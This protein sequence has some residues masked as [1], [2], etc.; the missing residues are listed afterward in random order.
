MEQERISE[1]LSGIDEDLLLDTMGEDGSIKKRWTSK[2]MVKIA[3][4]ACF[5]LLLGA[6]NSL[7]RHLA[8]GSTFLWNEAGTGYRFSTEEIREKVY[9]ER[10]NG[11]YYIFE[12]SELNITDYCSESDYFLYLNLDKNGTGYIVVVGG[13]EGER[14]YLLKH[15]QQGEL[16][17]GQGYSE[18]Y[19][20]ESSGPIPYFQDVINNSPQI[21]NFPQLIWNHH[22]THL[23]GDTLPS[24]WYQEDLP[25]I[26]EMDNGK[27]EKVETN[28]Y[29]VQVE[30]LG[31]LGSY[32]Q[33]NYAMSELSL[34]LD[35]LSSCDVGGQEH[36]NDVIDVYLHEKWTSQREAEAK[37]ILDEI[38]IPYDLNFTE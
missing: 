34:R 29:H 23:I 1:M 27:G 19:G 7:V 38:G 2:V 20:M 14:G 15:F 12:K 11:F 16:L 36:E 31:I 3:I 4:A 8:G 35:W 6:G 37:V 28:A 13:G 30:S 32:E 22:A 17:V 21:S 10:E 25:D 24:T 18:I 33:A 26:L 9:E 5:V